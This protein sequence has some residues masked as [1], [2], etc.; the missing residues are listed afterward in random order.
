MAVEA[1]GVAAQALLSFLRARRCPSNTVV[2][3]ERLLSVSVAQIFAAA[4]ASLM[5]PATRRNC[6]PRPLSRSFT[7]MIGRSAASAS[8]VRFEQAAPQRAQA[9]D[10]IGAA[11]ID[12]EFGALDRTAGASVVSVSVSVMAGAAAG[13]CCAGGKPGR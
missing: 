3:Q 9:V 5:G 10:R 4:A 1:A 7:T 2:S 12:P 8:L 11:E 6:M 13:R